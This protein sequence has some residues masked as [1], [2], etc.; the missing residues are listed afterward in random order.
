[1]DAKELRS[2]VGKHNPDLETRVSLARLG[3]SYDSASDVMYVRFRDIAPKNP[4]IGIDPEKPSSSV[5]LQVED[6]TWRIVGFDVIDWNR[7]YRRQIETRMAFEPIV[8]TFGTGDFR[9]QLDRSSDGELRTYIPRQI[10]QLLA[11]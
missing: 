8:R 2:L 9:V 4:V 10:R 6:E 1:M 7:V 11:A 3:V 5:Y